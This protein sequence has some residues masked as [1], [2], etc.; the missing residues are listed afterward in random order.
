MIGPAF[1]LPSTAVP[2]LGGLD[3]VGDGSLLLSL[4]YFLS[5]SAI[6]ITSWTEWNGFEWGMTVIGCG[7]LCVFG[8]ESAFSCNLCHCNLAIC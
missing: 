4:S 5:G 3:L 6:C 7:L 1:M 8:L 2:M